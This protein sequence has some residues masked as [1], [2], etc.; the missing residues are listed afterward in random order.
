MRDSSL[1]EKMY[2]EREAIVYMAVNALKR[3]LANGCRLSVPEI[4]KI[5]KEQ[6]KTE[7]SPVLS[8]YE[9]CCCDRPGGKISD[10]CTCSRMYDVFKAWCKD[11]GGYTPSRKMFRN[12]LADE[13]AGGNIS[14]IE[15]K[16]HGLWYY[17][18]TLNC[19]TKNTYRSV[20]GLDSSQIK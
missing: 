17:T 14:E 1:L 15:R 16:I 10:D 11:N 4:C 13:L 3:L 6:Y 18:F 5:E 20:Y 19:E 2:A 12:E 7:N 8:F 9:E